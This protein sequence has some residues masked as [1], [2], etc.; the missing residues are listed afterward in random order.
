[1]YH[2]G[3]VPKI[4]DDEYKKFDYMGQPITGGEAI[5]EVRSTRNYNREKCKTVVIQCRLG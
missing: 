1:M 3:F 4:W 5:P 2:K